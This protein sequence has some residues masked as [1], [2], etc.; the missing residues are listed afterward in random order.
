MTDYKKQFLLLPL[1][2][3]KSKFALVKKDLII[4]VEPRNDYTRVVFKSMDKTESYQTELS[5]K[6]IYDLL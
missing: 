3:N 6:E 2:K 5:T 1:D 4:E